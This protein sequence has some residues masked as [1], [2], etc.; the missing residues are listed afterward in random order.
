MVSE[1]ERERRI[2]AGVASM[3]DAIGEQGW[4]IQPVLASDT[5]PKFVYTIGL[6]QTYDHPEILITGCRDRVSTYLLNFIATRIKGGER[7]TDGVTDNELI[8][9]SNGSMPICFREIA[10][11]HLSDVCG[12]AMRVYQGRPFTAVQAYWSDEF[13]AFPWEAA[14]DDTKRPMQPMFHVLKPGYVPEDDRALEVPYPCTGCSRSHLIVV[15]ERDYLA[16][17]AASSTASPAEAFPYLAPELAA[18]MTR[19]G[20]G[21]CP[22]CL[23]RAGGQK[24]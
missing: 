8:E 3:R 4:V 17:S 16:F 6:H 15:A 24:P 18:M 22:Q 2:E 7:F 13:H 19:D 10:P 20:G 14:F 12:L 11:A 21:L 9:N 23:R 5:R 1:Q